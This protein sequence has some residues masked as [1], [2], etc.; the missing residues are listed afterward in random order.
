MPDYKI[1][2]TTNASDKWSGTILSFGE[3]WEA[4]CPVAFDSMTFK[5]AEINYPVH[6]KELL[7]II[8]AQ[9]WWVD[10]LGSEFFIYTNHKTLENFN[11]QKDL[12]WC[13]AQWME[14]MSQF[15][16]KII[17]IKGDYN[18]V[19]DALSCLPCTHSVIEAEQMAQ[20]P[21][22]FC[23]D[24]KTDNLIASILATDL[25]GPLDAATS[26]AECSF[27][28]VNATLN[29][30]ANKQFL[31]LIKAGYANYPWCKTLH[32]AAK[33]LP[34]LVVWDG[35][36]Y[37][38]ECLIIPQTGSLWETLFALAHDVLGNFGFDKMYS[39]LRESYLV[40]ESLVRSG[41]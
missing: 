31:E 16:A 24:D 32:S 14:F 29:I 28:S 2:V 11:M 4:A 35:L 39:S 36:W 5:G 33:S 6:E 10:L 30:T 20:H 18:S 8:C 21:Y 3:S 15:D 9:K 40:F 22:T 26:L 38:G 34:G 1:Y 19:A 25:H 23:M 13:Q 12:P 27:K 37:I 17:Y 41:Y 7:S